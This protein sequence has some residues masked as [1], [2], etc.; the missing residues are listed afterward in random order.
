MTCEIYALAPIMFHQEKPKV[1]YAHLNPTVFLIYDDF[2]TN[3]FAAGYFI[4]IYHQENSR[5][6][7]IGQINCFTFGP[8]LRLKFPTLILLST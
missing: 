8:L 7:I 6:G 1:K 3:A 2:Y 4:L 5:T